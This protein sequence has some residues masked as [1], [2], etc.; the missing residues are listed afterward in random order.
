M[1]ANKV[2]SSTQRESAMLETNATKGVCVYLYKLFL[3]LYK[4]TT[5]L[6]S[7]KQKLTDLLIAEKENR[8]QACE[9]WCALW[10]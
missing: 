7:A 1:A 4:I 9:S 5:L 10:A 8:N 6:I 2:F 3:H